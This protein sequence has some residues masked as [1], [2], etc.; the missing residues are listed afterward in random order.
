MKFI[1]KTKTY[2]KFLIF[3]IL[4][5]INTEE[6]DQTLASDGQESEKD[7]WSAAQDSGKFDIW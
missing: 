3:K 2:K 6:T 1:K 4:T 5:D 7:G